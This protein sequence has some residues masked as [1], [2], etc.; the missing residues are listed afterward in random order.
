MRARTAGSA[1]SPQARAWTRPIWSRAPPPASMPTMPGN[2]G[3]MLATISS[4]PG[5]AS[6]ASM[7]KCGNVHTEW[8]K[9]VTSTCWSASRRAWLVASSLVLTCSGATITSCPASRSTA[10]RSAPAR[11]M[12]SVTSRWT[13]SRPSEMDSRP[14]R[15]MERF[16]PGGP[17]G[18]GRMSAVGS[19]ESG[20][21]RRV[22]WGPGH[23]SPEVLMD[24]TIWRWKA[25][26]SASM[27][28]AAMVAAARM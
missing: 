20:G 6:A 25:K 19:G 13:K 28:S 16:L 21:V 7:V 8:W 12:W 11:A 17:D 2:C 3:S 26:N 18:W 24:S 15:A 27:G 5:V 9:T 10:A 14:M 22:R 23:L 1:R 4:G